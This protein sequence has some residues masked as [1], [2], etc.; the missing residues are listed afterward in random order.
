MTVNKNMEQPAQDKKEQ[1]KFEFRDIQ[2]M[3]EYLAWKQSV[4]KEFRDI[5]EGI[6]RERP[7]PVLSG[8]LGGL[9]GQ[10]LKG[11]SEIP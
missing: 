2:S 3:E 11:F 4:P 10:F 5:V 8:Q 6:L 9:T 7:S 1:K